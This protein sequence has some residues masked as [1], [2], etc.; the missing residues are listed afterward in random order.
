MGFTW[1]AG[2]RPQ[3]GPSLRIYLVQRESAQCRHSAVLYLCRR[4]NLGLH[5]LR[6]AIRAS[7]RLSECRVRALGST[8]GSNDLHLQ[9]NG[10]RFSNRV[11]EQSL[12]LPPILRFSALSVEHHAPCH[13]ASW[14]Y[15]RTIA[16]TNCCHS[17]TMHLASWTFPSS[18]SSW[19]WW[20]ACIGFS[21][22]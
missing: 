12:S 5:S 2:Q 16:L 7:Y 15:L 11:R 1:R 19:N 6:A 18:Y 4:S 14:I 21:C 8:E 10:R 20:D 17:R 22:S 9:S 3:L 13:P